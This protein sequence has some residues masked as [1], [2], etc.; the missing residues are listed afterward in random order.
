[1]RV[2]QLEELGKKKV[3]LHK[4]DQRI[5]TL[6]C[7]NA[8]LPLSKIAELLKLS[9]QSIEYRIRVMQKEHLLAGSRAVI[10]IK[11]LGYQS[12]H[13]FLTVHNEASEKELIHRCREHDHVNVLISYS[14]Q[15]NYE[16]SIMARHPAEAQKHFLELIKELVIVDYVSTILLDT[17]KASVLPS[18]VSERVPSLKY[19]RNDPSFSKHFSLHEIDYKIDEKDLAILYILSQDAQLSIAEVS[20]KLHLSRDTLAYR[21]KK[22]IRSRYILEFRP[23]IDYSVLS[24]SVQTVLL[25]ANR[26]TIEDEKFRRYLK[27]QNSVLW[28][29]EVFGSWDFLLYIVTNSQEEINAFIDTLRKKFS[30]YLYSY[31]I[32]F[33]YQEHKYAFMTPAMKGKSP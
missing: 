1:M 7:M 30:S 4:Y 33:A 28:A 23:V 24:L 31:E 19:I 21:I 8:R 22:L 2:L 10:N 27:E 14:G 26:A 17:I 20:K 32:L 6:L 3:I 18:I 25:K 12:Y 9:R 15:W 13:Y 11:K 5:L 16:L 29:T